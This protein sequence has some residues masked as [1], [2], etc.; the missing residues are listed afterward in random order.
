VEIFDS[1]FIIN[2]QF[3]KYWIKRLNYSFLR[4]F[5]NWII[6]VFFVG[7]CRSFSKLKGPGKLLNSQCHLRN[8]KKSISIHNF[9]ATPN[10]KKKFHGKLNNRIFK[11]LWIL[12]I[13]LTFSPISYPF[14]L[15]IYSICNLFSQST[16]GTREQIFSTFF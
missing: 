14:F 12:R 5:F 4:A 11:I 10:H 7:I 15:L 16:H 2:L 6:R 1:E 8:P 3:R 9:P 13:Q